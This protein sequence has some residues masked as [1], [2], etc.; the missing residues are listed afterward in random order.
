MMETV[1]QTV[2]K[3]TIQLPKNHKTWEIKM[4]G[5]VDDKNIT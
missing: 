1:E 5:F 2:P 3:C 4:L